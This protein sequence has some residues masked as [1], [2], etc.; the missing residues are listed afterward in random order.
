M[1]LCILSLWVIWIFFFHFQKISIICIVSKQCYFHFTCRTYRL[2]YWCIV[3]IYRPK[4][5]K[6][7]NIQIKRLNL[8]SFF[9]YSFIQIKGENYSFTFII[10]CH[11]H[12]ILCDYFTNNSLWLAVCYFFSRKI[13]TCILNLVCSVRQVWILHCSFVATL[14]SGMNSMLFICSNFV[15]P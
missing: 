2:S 8:K 9:F 13:N 4:N 7:C 6:L 15:Q 11:L 5:I 1:A 3:Y 12:R 14:S 10:I